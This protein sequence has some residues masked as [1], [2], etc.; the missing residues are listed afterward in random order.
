MAKPL[1]WRDL[2]IGMLSF[3]A[4]LAAAL[5]VL[6]FGR[7]GTLHGK[8]FYVYVTT[9]G[10]RGVIRGTEVWLDGQKVGLVRDVAFQPP[11]VDSTNRVV[12]KLRVL[13]SAQSHIRLDSRVQV[14]AGTAV[15]GDRVVYMSSGTARARQVADGDTV[16]SSDQVDYESVSADAAAA[17]K[18]FP[19]IIDNVKLL[20]AQLESVDGT[21]GAFGLEGTGAGISHVHS[22]VSQLMERLSSSNGT[23]SLGLTNRDLLLARA[24]RA[25]AQTDSIRALLNSNEHSLGRFRRDSTLS[26]HVTKLKATL[27]SLQRLAGSPNGTI[28]RLRADSAITENIQR[29]RAA[30]DSLIADMKKHPLRYTP[31]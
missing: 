22:R 3:T 12:M 17:T 23:V 14:R 2:K 20:S 21:L 7:V 10:A 8:T 19:A 27:D 29:A 24:R 1:R 4:V 28:G 31:F 6:I 25:L 11:S 5:G 13:Q 16:H 18:E 15:I 30:L 26:S 9:S